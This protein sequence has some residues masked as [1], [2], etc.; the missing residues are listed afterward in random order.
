MGRDNPMR[1]YP[2]R[3]AERGGA[4]CVF[5]RDPFDGER[6]TLRVNVSDDNG[7]PIQ[8]SDVHLTRDDAK[9]LFVY[10][11]DWLFE[12]DVDACEEVYRRW[13]E[14]VE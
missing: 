7:F 5:R 1:I 14:M 6:A 11:A 8:T 13:T 2:V 3:R 12:G 9:R 4:E 10:L